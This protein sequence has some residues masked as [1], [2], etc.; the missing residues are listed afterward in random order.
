M[1]SPIY[2]SSTWIKK[3]GFPA[4]EK[5]WVARQE[6]YNQEPKGFQGFAINMRKNKFKDV[7]VRE[8]LCYLL[9]RELMNQK[10][11]HNVY[12]LLNSYFPDLYSGYVNPNIP[13][14]TY[15]PDK[16]RGL[17]KVA[18]WQINQQGQLA[19]VESGKV[20]SI[21]FIT[22]QEDLRHLICICGRPKKS[23]NPS[24]Y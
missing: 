10:L 16:A 4:V 12:F 13:V 11:M 9:N 21:Q 24:H 1:H 19:N 14:T 22:A 18:G 17:L 6:I 15:D 20:F 7:R 23:R 5:G 3:T 8:A 2:T